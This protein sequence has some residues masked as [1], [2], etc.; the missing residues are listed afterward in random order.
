VFQP[1]EGEPS[2][3]DYPETD[4]EKDEL[5]AFAAAV[6]GEKPFPV[7]VDDAVHS[8]AVLEAMDR[9]AKTGQA[10]KI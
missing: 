10:V 7:T 8:V 4:P 9:S 6:T 1:I 3:I 2:S 5:E